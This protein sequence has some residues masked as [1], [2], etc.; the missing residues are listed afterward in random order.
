MTSD[1]YPR[2]TNPDKSW[3]YAN[4]QSMPG[5]EPNEKDIQELIGLCNSGQMAN[6]ANRAKELL[7]KHRGSAILYNILG[8]SLCAQGK[9]DEAASSYRRTLTITPDDAQ[10][11]ISLGKALMRLGKPEEAA[12]NLQQALRIDPNNAYAHGILGITLARLGKADEALASFREAVRI[13]PRNAGAHSNLGNGLATVGKVEE[14]VVSYQQA[15]KIN[16]NDARAHNNLGY[17]FTLLGKI[18]E[19]K[20]SYYQA[21]RLNPNDETYFNLH[22]LLLDLDDMSLAINCLEAAVKLRP[23]NNTHKFFLGMLLEYSGRAENDNIYFT[24]VQQGSDLD[25]ARLDAWNYIKSASD[26]MPRMIGSSIEAFRFGIH[27]APQS[28]LMLEFGVE[29][30]VSIRQIAGL[31]TEQ[32]H[33]FDSFEG[34]PDVWHCEAKGTYTTNGVI[35]DVP[36]NVILHKGWFE[37]TLPEFVKTHKDPVRF[38]NIDCDLYS[39]TKT[40]LDCLSSQIVPGTIIIFDEYIGNTHWREDEFKAFQEAVSTYGWHYEYIAF[41]MVTKQV[42]V[43]MV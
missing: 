22:P 33:G 20:A 32:I 36:G 19:A 12:A 39:S 29:F 14:A 9:F 21:L 23:S 8:N 24:A 17:A 34:L 43:R 37:N 5:I 4:D 6:A 7:E 42:V 10:T 11:H 27:S 38:M 2:N 25:R 3:K 35:P 31:V 41:S 18:D 16:P 13:D 30:G 15:L 28:G 40:V 26:K 1:D